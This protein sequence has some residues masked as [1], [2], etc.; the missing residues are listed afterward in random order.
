MPSK[1]YSLNLGIRAACHKRFGTNIARDSAPNKSILTRVV[2]ANILLAVK[3]RRTIVVRSLFHSGQGAE[4]ARSIQR[5]SVPAIRCWM[6]AMSGI[7]P[8]AA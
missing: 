4:F 2:A 7:F 6:K 8:T 5:C 1:Y 3:S